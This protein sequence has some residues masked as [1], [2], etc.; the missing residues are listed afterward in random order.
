VDGAASRRGTCHTFNPAVG[1]GQVVIACKEAEWLHS[2][3]SMMMMHVDR[4]H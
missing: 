4:S 2:G 1:Q 3:P